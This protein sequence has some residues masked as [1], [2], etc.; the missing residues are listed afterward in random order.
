MQTSARA[1]RR[2]LLGYAASLGAALCYGA[3]QVVARHIVTN[4]A[5][6]LVLAAYSFLFGSLFLYPLARQDISKALESPRRTL[7][8]LIGAGLASTWGVIFVTLALS[9]APVVVVAPIVS[10]SPLL[11]V[12]LTHLFLRRVER[13]T[14]RVVGGTLLVVGGVTLVILGA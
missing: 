5:S 9:R 13:V 14:P 12:L 3:G 11:T 1:D 7:W 4:V 6:P 8:L 2:Q 10:I